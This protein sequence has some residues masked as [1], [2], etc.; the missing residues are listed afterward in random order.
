MTKPIPCKCGSDKIIPHITV[1][2]PTTVKLLCYS[3]DLEGEEAQTHK[4]AVLN[5]NSMVLSS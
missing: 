5:W 1:G 3:C 4:D 2:E